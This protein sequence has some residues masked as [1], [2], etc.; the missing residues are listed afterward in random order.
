MSKFIKIS[1]CFVLIFSIIFSTGCESQYLGG[2]RNAKWKKDLSYLEEALPKKH[3]NLFF[4]TSKEQFHNDISNLKNSVDKSNDDE[5][6][7]GI[8]KIMASIGDAHSSAYKEFSKIYP[9][10]FYYFKDGIYVINTTSQYKEALYSKLVKINGIDIEKVKQAIIPLIVA[11]NEGMIKKGIPKYLSN[12]EILHG[13]KITKDTE[14]AVF[15]FENDKG[16]S[17]DINIKSVDRGKGDNLIVNQSP[18]SSY[19]LYM[20][21]TELN[22]WYKYLDKEKTLYFKY[23]KCNPDE[24]EKAPKIEDFITDMLKFIDKHPVDKFVIDMR[25]NGGGSDKYI[26]PII[27][28]LKNSKLNNKNSLFVIVGRDTFSAAMV[29]TVLLKKQTNA[30]FVGESTSAKPSHY[31]AVKHLTLPNSKIEV[32]YST[33]FNE[34]DDNDSEGSLDDKLNTFMPDKIIEISINDYVNK[35]D[36]ILDYILNL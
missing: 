6:V 3:A 19:P 20:Q 30:T 32:G 23:N 10:Q 13:I 27:D 2:D 17:F 25:T 18:D 15:T 34:A 22:Y 11:E 21:K 36:P 12:P 29:D 9:V 7:A 1:F 35:K 26:V 14:K 28:K 8:Y 4:K 16:E 5:I 33:Q 24:D 31:G